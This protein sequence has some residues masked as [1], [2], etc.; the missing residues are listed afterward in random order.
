MQKQLRGEIMTVSEARKI[1]EED[2]RAYRD[3]LWGEILAEF[4][5]R[6]K[7]KKEAENGKRTKKDSEGNGKTRHSDIPFST[8][9]ESTQTA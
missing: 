2:D 4:H 1:V 7:T 3:E 6:E 8:E 9:H 5:H